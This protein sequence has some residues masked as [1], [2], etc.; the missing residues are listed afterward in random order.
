MWPAIAGKINGQMSVLPSDRPR[1]GAD[2]VSNPPPGSSR[3][4]GVG[5]RGI[6]AQAGQQRVVQGPLNGDN[7]P[8]RRRPAACVPGGSW[9]RGR[10]AGAGR[11]RGKEQRGGPIRPRPRKGPLPR[12]PA[13]G[14]LAT[15]LS[16]P[17]VPSCQASAS[18]S[19]AVSQRAPDPPADARPGSDPRPPPWQSAGRWMMTGTSS[20]EKI[21]GP[22]PCWRT[23][24]SARSPRGPA[25]SL[26]GSRQSRARLGYLRRSCLIGTSA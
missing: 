24:L 25:M 14:P 3:A 21:R 1:G 4:P 17:R 16:S 23:S 9:R 8:P 10:A 13:P 5:G 12:R 18:R 20:L 19:P 2:G 26:S 7:V 15:G 22:R 11:A 6:D